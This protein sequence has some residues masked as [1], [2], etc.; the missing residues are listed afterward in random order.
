MF[1]NVA[2]ATREKTRERN[3]EERKRRQRIQQLQQVASLLQQTKSELGNSEFDISKY[4]EKFLN[5]K[6]NMEPGL[7]G[8]NFHSRSKSRSP[9]PPNRAASF[10]DDAEDVARN[11]YAHRFSRN[12]Y[13][14]DP[15]MDMDDATEDDLDE[16]DEEGN[17]IPVPK[18]MLGKPLK[19]F[20]S[21]QENVS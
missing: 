5:D 2:K 8:R 7:F 11:E 18:C 9:R 16:E 3:A 20:D 12:D 14:N 13:N 10:L 4:T 6:E 15:Y 17:H 1:Y 21:G 19:D